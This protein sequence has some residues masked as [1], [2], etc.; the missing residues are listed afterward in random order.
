M[1]MVGHAAWNMPPLAQ[2]AGPSAT[3]CGGMCHVSS[4][5]TCRHPMVILFDKLFERWSF[6][7]I[8]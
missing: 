8:H 4:G 5:K 1:A 3:G 6:L 2:A 7:T